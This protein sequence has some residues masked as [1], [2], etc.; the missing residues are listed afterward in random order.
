M[1][2]LLV[3]AAFALLA[4]TPS[5]RARGLLIPTERTCRRW[6][7]STTRSTSPSRIRSPSPR[8]EQTFRNH[9]DRQLEATYVFPVP[10]GASVNKFTM[11]VDGK[12]VPANWSRPT[13]PAR[14]TPTSSAAR[15]TPA[16]SNTSATT[17]C[18]LRVFPMPPT[19]DQK[20]AV[21]YTS[22][23][24]AG[25]RPGRVRLSAQDRRQGRRHAGEVLRSRRRSSRSIRCRTS[26][27]RRMPSRS[28]AP[29]ISEVA[30]AFDA[31]PG[32]ARQGFPALLLRPAARTSA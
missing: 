4:V 6:R 12:E 8:V 27:A 25:R 19:G 9:T 24:A 11:W 32:R 28:R 13:R 7:C 5:V 17:C 21:S 16:C 29:T 2:R 3:L 23:A 10:K 1:R 26:T 30:V 18:K 15:R 31:E 22:V 14:S 20:V